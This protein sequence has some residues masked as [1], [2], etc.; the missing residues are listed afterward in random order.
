MVGQ[1][2]VIRFIR[3]ATRWRRFFR[4]S[5]AASNQRT[6]DVSGSSLALDDD[7]H[8]VRVLGIRHFDNLH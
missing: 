2:E 4:C 6:R 1:P 7:G 8:L 5:V 3:H